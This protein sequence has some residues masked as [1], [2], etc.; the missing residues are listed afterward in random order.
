MSKKHFIALAA[1]LSKI[2]CEK[3]RRTAAEAVADF[4]AADNARFDRARFL[5]ACGLK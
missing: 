5:T 1:A 3:C 4:S 2:D